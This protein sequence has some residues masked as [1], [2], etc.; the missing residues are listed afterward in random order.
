MKNL[1][2]NFNS[3]IEAG[4]LTQKDVV[5]GE[6]EKIGYVPLYDYSFEKFKN[7]IIEA[8]KNIEG[9]EGVEIEFIDREQFKA[10]VAIK[11][12]HLMKTRGIPVYT[13]EFIPQ[14]IANLEAS[15]FFKEHIEKITPTGIYIN[16]LMKPGFFLSLLNDA[17]TLGDS[18]GLS[19]KHKGE[20]IVLDYSSPNMA[21]HLHAGHVR[22]TLIGEVLAKIYE[23][24]GY[25]VH[26]LN[27][28]NDWGGMG[29][30]MEAYMRLSA[31][32]ALP[33]VADANDLLYQIYLLV[34][35]AEKTGTSN[36]AEKIFEEAKE[37]LANLVG[38]FADFADYK[39]KYAEFLEAGRARF[40]NLEA[41]NAEEFLLWQKMRDWSLSEFNKFYEILN[42][43]HDYLLGE[44]FYS[45]SG[46]DLVKEK[47]AGGMVV[48]FTKELADEEVR[49]SQL[50]FEA[51]TIKKTVLEKLL[52]EIS[53]DIGAYVVM[54]PSGARM[55]VMRADGATIYATRDLVSAKHRLETFLP[56]R[57]V[58]EV[59][60]EQTEHFKHLFEAVLAL[61]LNKGAMVDLKHV[62][63][64]FYVDADTGQKLSSREGAQNVVSL[65]EESIKYFRNKYD[66]RST[67]ERA[68]VFTEDEKEKNSRLLAIG[69]ITFNDIKQDKKFPIQFHKELTKNIKNFEE[70]GG[71]YIMYSIARARSILRKSDKK[72][73]DIDI[74]SLD[75]T[76]LEQI[77][78]NLIKKVAE[79]PRIILKAGD[80]DNPAVLA[81]YLL[82][83]ANEYNS[84]YEN[85]EVLEAGK[86]AYPH[87]LLISSAV[88]TAM[89]N[90]LKLCH[91][92]AP[93][94]I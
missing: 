83:L 18:Y 62:Y 80:T 45:K 17:L 57:L 73:S 68:Q 44:S 58:Y 23:A 93:E 21:K 74:D 34:R 75:L 66:E 67:G 38:E 28:L 9:F 35:K 43:K 69:S 2:D 72:V 7:S 19:D 63:H 12:P 5:L 29:A 84:Y 24:T 42:I 4:V 6:R 79:L 32:N 94:R 3:G 22:S 1:L 51:G 87:R 82:H 39:N 13:K 90:G 85:F 91:A 20:S 55:V 16:L 56:S 48:Q 60:Q 40:K 78:I 92:E 30:I 33:K 27:Y 71:A 49:K 65:V 61:N 25:T 89:A 76:K 15:D 64:G 81:E 77:E 31:K 70:S 86:L 11:V 14:I 54:L 50:A 59:G 37:E 41:G 46:A 47:L 52:Q 10:D 88:A 36:T 8:N 26:R 53:H